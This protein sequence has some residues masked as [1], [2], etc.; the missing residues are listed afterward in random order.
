MRRILIAT[1]GSPCSEEAIHHFLSLVGGL[2][3]A[4]AFVLSV[5]SPPTLSIDHPNYDRD[6][7]TG[8]DTTVAAID[9]A[10]IELAYEGFSAVGL[11]RVGDPADVIVEVAT[12]VGADLIVLGTHGSEGLARLMHESV[13]ENVL[14]RAPCGV[15]IYPYQPAK[16]AVTV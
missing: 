11:T 10:T 8:F 12:E 6:F 4:K 1:E 14:H 13:A 15:L 5:V 3:D 9:M 7:Q 16:Q 2:E